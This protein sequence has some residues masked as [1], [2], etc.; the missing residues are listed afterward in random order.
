MV[1]GHSMA[2]PRPASMPVSGPFE[3]VAQLA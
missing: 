3:G 2:L 1:I